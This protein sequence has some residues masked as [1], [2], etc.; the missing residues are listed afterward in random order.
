MAE[1]LTLE[2]RR[3][4]DKALCALVAEY[5][6]SYDESACGVMGA[7]GKGSSVAEYEDSYDESACGVMGA[8]GKGSSVAE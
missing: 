1:V 5:E 3:P 7:V 4:G 8:V 2:E 6:D